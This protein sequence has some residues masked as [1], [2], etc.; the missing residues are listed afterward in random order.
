MSEFFIFPGIGAA[1]AGHEHQVVDLVEVPLYEAFK[2]CDEPSHKDRPYQD[3]PVVGTDI[4]F[5][6][7]DPC[8]DIHQ[9]QEEG[10]DPRPDLFHFA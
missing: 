6:F 10:V 2:R 3:H 1:A 8:I 7:T 4:V 9:E 5:Q